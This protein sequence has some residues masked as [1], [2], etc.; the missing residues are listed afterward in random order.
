MT[1]RN[2][3]GWVAIC[4]LA[5]ATLTGC[6]STWGPDASYWSGTWQTEGN[7]EYGGELS[8]IAE[9]VDDQTWRAEF[10]GYCGRE[11]AYEVTMAG[12]RDGKK[13][14]FAGSA[15][16]GDEDGGLYDWTGEIDDDQFTGKYFSSAGKRGGFTMTRDE[17]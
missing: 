2:R 9:R 7:Q 12:K 5:A 14:V 10:T 17:D 15:D 13:V 16:L 1:H 4:C 6:E 11:F 8:C 3:I